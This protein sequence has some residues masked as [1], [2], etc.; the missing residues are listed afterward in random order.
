M[1]EN[2]DKRESQ[3]VDESV[4]A[5]PLDPVRD[6]YNERPETDVK[7]RTMSPIIKLRSFNNFIKSAL[8]QAYGFHKSV[9]LDI[10]CGKGGDLLKWSKNRTKGYIGIDIADVSI[11]QARERY[12]N[13]KHKSFWADFC[14]GDAYGDTVENIVHPDAFPVDIVSIQFSMHYA[15]ENEE[16]ARMMISNVSRALKRGGRFLGTI[17]N[18]DM[19]KSRIDNLAPGQSGWGNSIY[20]VK[21]EGTPPKVFRQP[22][23]LKYFF[24]LQDAVTNVPE[25]IVPFEAFRALAQEYDL[26][27]IYKKPFLEMFDSETKRNPD[28]LYRLCE[29]M[30]V[31]KSDGSFGIE[32][33]ER[34]ACEFYLAFAF[35]KVR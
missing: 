17:P 26:E 16:R 21:F 7:L 12:D 31:V 23:G 22:Y 19:I 32:G 5:K 1:R 25:Y 33:E 2:L 28:F 8:I 13:L 15:Y 6:H 20:S 14:V 34:E 10:G 27:L 3:S 24:Y 30:G 11:S 35:E 29:K 4:A 9:V 18:S